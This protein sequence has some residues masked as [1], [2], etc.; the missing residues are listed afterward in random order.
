VTAAVPAM[1][2]LL[3]QLAP[4]PAG[5]NAIPAPAACAD[6]RYDSGTPGGSYLVIL[7]GVVF[8]TTVREDTGSVRLD[9]NISGND[10][11]MF[12]YNIN[13]S[14]TNYTFGIH[15]GQ[16]AP[17]ALRTQYGKIDETHIFSPKALN[18]FS[19]A[20]NR[21]YSDTNS[22]TPLVGFAGFFANL[23]SLPGP[24]IF[25]QIT[26]FTVL[27][28]F[29]TLTRTAG[30]HTLKVGTQI[31]ANRFNE[32]LRPQQTYY[33]G[34]FHDLFND[35]PFVLTKIG[36][37]GFIGIRN[38]NWDF[39]AQ[40]DWRVARTVTLNLGLRYDYNTAWRE[41]HN[42]I[43]N[44]DVA[45]QSFLPADQ[46]VYEA[47]KGDFAPRAGIAWDPFGKG[48]TVIHGFGGLFYLPMQFGFG[49]TSNMPALA[50]YSVN[51][52][53][54]PFPLAYPSPNP[55]LIPGTQNVTA[56]PPHPKDPYA[57]NWLFGIE[58][59]LP[60]QAILTLNYTGNKTQHMQAG[61]SYAALNAN[62]AN[63]VTQARR[64]SGFADE[65][66]V[67]NV[68]SSNYD[69]FQVQ[70]R[71]NSGRLNL[72]ANYTW[73][74][75]L[76]DLVNAFD[77][78]SDPYDPSKD[79]SSGDID[80]RHN[81]TAGLVY[82]L[83]EL[84]GSRSGVRGLLGGW[85]TSS[86]IQ[87]RSGL[88]VNVQLLS[89]FFSNPMRPNYVPG[90]SPRL[91]NA[92][93]PSGSYNINAFAIEPDFN[94]E[95]GHVSGDVG[96]NALRGPSFFQWDFSVMKNF[97]IRERGQF[98]FR[99]DLFNILNH[100]NFANPDGGICTSITPAAFAPNGTLVTPASCTPNTPTG[101]GGFGISGGTI[102]DASQGAIGNG[103]AR[104]AQFSLKL[105]F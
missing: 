23:G 14:L 69:A 16:V 95:W 46:P 38:S 87:T 27:E 37:P 33:F 30:R 29:D 4:L 86:I 62:P 64:F 103:T 99:A 9:Y 44:F 82:S 8:P 98:Q 71:R 32:W 67:A 81:F 22:N 55:P 66:V 24:N 48:K 68:L 41:R 43:R 75:E 77:A 35:A 61:A 79:R 85:Q 10:R 104:Q 58:Q 92:H 18:E 50:S 53:Q 96:R 15:Q 56:F 76:D 31:R 49:L 3:A 89:G 42:Q 72:Q 101:F 83:P 90:Q 40:D 78:F 34:S 39:Y 80:V 73:S 1:R 84:N 91:D 6:S 57:T 88:P 63:T 54:A 65:N 47:P 97:P 105:F 2:P 100:P 11:L 93:W 36:F 5:C 12:R 26:P 17:E 20:V 28:V 60:A 13:D 74:H 25:N 21:F 70:V 59:Q 7:R 51:V 52:F 19:V 102:A 45:T 94:G